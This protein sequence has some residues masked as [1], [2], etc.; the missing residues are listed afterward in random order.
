MTLK[1]KTDL[2]NNTG[3]FDA[4][5]EIVKTERHRMNFMLDRDVFVKFKEKCM[6]NYTTPSAKMRECENARMRE[7]IDLYL[8]E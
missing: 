4:Q 2:I 6:R 3:I 5:K 8:I 7:W 1:I